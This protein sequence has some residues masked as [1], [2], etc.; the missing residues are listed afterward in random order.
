MWG[1]LSN[2]NESHYDIFVKIFPC[3]NPYQDHLN[4][5]NANIQFTKEIK[6]NEM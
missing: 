6:E 3:T 5:Q 1:I 4:Q 2:A